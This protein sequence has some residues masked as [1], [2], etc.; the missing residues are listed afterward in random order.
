[1]IKISTLLD[2]GYYHPSR[3]LTPEES[4]RVREG[5]ITEEYYIYFEEGDENTTEYQQYLIAR[6][7]SPEE[8]QN[9]EE[10]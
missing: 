9:L 8:E 1:M 3:I 10:S 7:P 4:A 2:G 6:Q 5:W